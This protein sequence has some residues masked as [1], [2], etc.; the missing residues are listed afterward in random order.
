MPALRSSGNARRDRFRPCRDECRRRGNAP[1]RRA[2]LDESLRGGDRRI[3][4][5]GVPHS[6]AVEGNVH[7]L[8]NVDLAV[9]IPG[10]VCGLQDA[11]CNAR[12]EEFPIPGAVLFIRNLPRIIATQNSSQRLPARTGT[13]ASSH[14]QPSRSAAHGRPHSSQGSMSQRGLAQSSLP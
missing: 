12:R 8:P 1:A 11:R 4:W 5:H 10:K 9:A 14:A 6:I 3:R 13:P 2:P 7:G